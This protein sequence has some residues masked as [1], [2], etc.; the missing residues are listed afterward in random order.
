MHDKSLALLSNSVHVGRRRLAVLLLTSALWP[1]GCVPVPAGRPCR[2]ESGSVL[3]VDPDSLYFGRSWEQDQFPFRLQVRNNSPQQVQVLRVESSCNCLSVEPRSFTIP[4]NGEISL[5][6]RLDLRRRRFVRMNRWLFRSELCAVVA[7]SRRR[8]SWEVKGEVFAYPLRVVPASLWIE[9][10]VGNAHA[11]EGKAEIRCSGSVTHVDARCPARFAS[12]RI[13]RSHARSQSYDLVLWPNQHLPP[14]EHAFVLSLK[15]TLR[16]LPAGLG[17]PPELRIPVTLV[18][19]HDVYASPRTV[20]FGFLPLGGCRSQQI[21]LR[22]FARRDFSVVAIE[23]RPDRRVTVQPLET[24][25]RGVRR[26]RI[27][28]WADGTGHRRVQ[29]RFLVRET[30]RESPPYWV[31]VPVTYYGTT[32]SAPDSG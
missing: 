25:E 6:L 3:S 12:A 8:Q 23:V 26:Y 2:H 22:S 24:S 15:P 30:R 18:V 16:E 19:R 28:L 21:T 32:E 4:G 1:W 14:G 10:F 13:T 9:T 20:A 17:P 27:R 5:N 31:G 29:V 11:V 7:D